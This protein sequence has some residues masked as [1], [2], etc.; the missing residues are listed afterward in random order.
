MNEKEWDK[1]LTRVSKQIYDGRMKPGSMNPAMVQR[2][3]NELMGAIETGYGSSF[4]DDGLKSTQFDTLQ[5]LEKNV[6]HFSG[7]KNWNQLREMSKLLL[8]DAGKVKS[9]KQFLNDV[10][11]VDATYN[12]VYLQAEYDTALTSAK[13]AVELSTT[14]L[15]YRDMVTTLLAQTGQRVEALMSQAEATNLVQSTAGP[16]LKC[17]WLS[18]PRTKFKTSR[19]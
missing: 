14:N 5:V 3:A 9:F 17:V 2:T 16:M 18:L 15:E 1:L 4:A 19:E 7:A 6:F 8:D 13:K 11:T 10:R 12:K